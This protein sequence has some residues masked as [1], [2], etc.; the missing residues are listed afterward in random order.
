MASPLL[1]TNLPT[2]GD[3]IMRTKTNWI[4]CQSA[5]FTVML[6]ASFNVYSFDFTL[7]SQKIAP[8]Q[9]QKKYV[10]AETGIVTIK[11]TAAGVITQQQTATYKETTPSIATIKPTAANVIEKQQY[12][13]KAETGTAAIKPTA[14]VVIEKQQ[15]YTKAES[16]IATIKPTDAGVIAQQQT[17]K[18]EETKP[19]IVTVKPA[20][21]IIAQQQ[22]AV[23]KNDYGLAATANAG[24]KIT[25]QAS[26]KASTLNLAA[27]SP[28]N[29]TALQPQ[30][31]STS[32]YQVYDPSSH[33]TGQQIAT[34]ETRESQSLGDIRRDPDLSHTIAVPDSGMTLEITIN[35]FA[36]DESVTVAA[37]FKGLHISASSE[38]PRDIVQGDCVAD[39]TS[40]VVVCTLDLGARPSHPHN[41]VHVGITDYGKANFSDID[42]VIMDIDGNVVV[43]SALVSG[44]LSIIRTSDYAQP[45]VLPLQ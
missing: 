32:Q 6:L 13:T 33:L 28:A 15:Y 8:Q 42:A 39:G 4:L 1:I 2:L 26:V 37:D 20:T 40:E 43:S 27:V 12:Y 22:T 11:P 24:I 16:S 18:Y 45:I 10:K 29:G 36:I 34:V 19:S 5:A 31:N 35:G 3:L 14:A 23:V 21:G 41:R 7:A 17:Y 44:S 38:D 9:Q 25:Q 30:Q